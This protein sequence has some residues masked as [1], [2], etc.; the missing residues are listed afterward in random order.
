MK[1]KM[2]VANAAMLTCLFA[3]CAQAADP[4]LAPVPVTGLRETSSTQANIEQAQQTIK[5]IPG[6]ASVVDMAV[7]R[8]GRV[9]TWTDS[10]GLAP[11]VYI[12]DRFGSEEARITIRG[13]ALSRTY[14]SFGLTVM[15]DGIPIN[16]AD[17]F[18][19]MQTID[20]SA[21]RHVEVLRGANA[22]SYASSTLGGAINF[23]SPTGYDSPRFLGR[24]EAGSF[25]YGRLQA[26]TGVVIRPEAGDGN[27]WDY[28]LSASAM[29]QEGYRAHSAQQS[30]KAVANAGVRVSKDLESRFFFAAV[31]SRSQLP[32]Y[33]TRAQLQSDPSV[34]QASWPDS[35]QR[36]DVDSLRLANK[37][38]FTQG[39]YRLELAA[40]ALQQ[41]L[42]HPIIYGFIAQDANTFGAQLKLFSS[43]R[44]LNLPNTLSIAYLPDTGTTRG[45]THA[46]AAGFAQ[47]ALTSD[48]TQKSENHRVLIEDRLRIS[49]RTL[50][51]ASLQYQQASRTFSDSK[52]ALGNYDLQ[53]SQWV[54][55][56]GIVHDITPH[57]QWFANV[58]RNFEPPIFG[59]ATSMQATRAQTGNTAE[60]GARGEHFWREGYDQLSW[61]V[62]LYRSWINDEFQTMCANGVA[63]CTNAFGQTVTVNVPRTVHQG[64]ELGA[65]GLIS[66]RWESRMALLVSDFR[67][68]GDAQYGNNRL[69]GFPPVMLRGELLYRW[70]AAQNGRGLPSS[71]AGPTLEWAP[72]RA[73]MDNTNSV[74]NDRYALLG[75]K[76]G[77]ALDATWSWFIDARNLTNEKYAATTNIGASFQGNSGA[78][79]YPGMARSA[80]AGIEGKW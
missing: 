57:S 62:T 46:V 27:L 69:P 64:L 55:R 47:G 75:F 23:V 66:R 71:Y 35:F 67:F 13:S 24:A 70:G 30:E 63:V 77:G 68:D 14:H 25:G 58:S 33:V 52:Q 60:I 31:R 73:P 59:V 29:T 41:Q 44:L 5:T 37:T 56:L 80:Y 43:A 3:H 10:L 1:K 42:W 28:H 65:S 34:A 26:A 79:Y 38:V 18:F 45:S 9:S 6:G 53:F 54:P 22:A 72:T 21:A 49:E 76:T 4:T 39:D 2:A 15:Q 78:A 20:S 36:R 40:Y 11:G 61:D 74:S 16:Y 7:V 32:G 19:D 48:Y 8:E 12:Q 50:L 17:G 51:V